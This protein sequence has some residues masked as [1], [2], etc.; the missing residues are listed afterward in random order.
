LYQKLK[1][2]REKFIIPI[3]LIYFILVFFQISTT[4]LW[5]DEIMSL[6][7]CDGSFGDL[8]YELAKDV[9]AP[10]Y[11]T[12][13]F[14]FVKVGGISE[15]VGRLPGILAGCGAILVLFF[16]ARDLAGLAA[17]LLSCLFLACSPFFLEFCREVHPYSL[18]AFLAVGSW[19]FFLQ[20]FKKAEI[21]NALSYSIF[22]G[23]L[24]LNFYLSF[25]IIVCQI[26]IFLLVKISRKKRIMII[27]SWFGSVLLFCPW[28]PVF[29]YQL[30]VNKISHDVEVYFPDGIKPVHS[31]KLLSDIF[32]GTQAQR[33]GLGATG[34]VLFLFIFAGLYAFFRLKRS[35]SH[36]GKRFFY[37]IILWS[38]WGL[39]IVFTL[40][41]L[42]KPLYL[43]RY[44]TMSAPFA[45]LFL[46]STFSF[47][48]R[49]KVYV[50][51]GIVIILFLL[52]Y[53]QYHKQMPR[54]NWREPTLYLAEQMKP[55]DVLI[56]DHMNSASCFIFYLGM[57][58]RPEL[59]KNIFTFEHFT[60]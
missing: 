33:L 35:K 16:L 43:S 24:L 5:L 22:S 25:L 27:F 52:S 51:A 38:F 12:I 11:Y 14:L 26:I 42:I 13:L 39:F 58:G 32:F 40:T 60:S 49:K 31:L 17:A 56:T 9:H 36:K 37:G 44:M 3:I 45:A 2:S 4:S 23:L 1:K 7:F 34:L 47:L 29:L 15:W 28:I 21:K 41:C 30:K 59:R 10:L 18:S 54:E 46:G 55:N 20:L 48:L 19:Y 50:P 57:K 6:D 8:Y 53:S